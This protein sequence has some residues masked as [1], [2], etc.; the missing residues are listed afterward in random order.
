MALCS[1]HYGEHFSPLDVVK[2]DWVGQMVGANCDIL[3]WEPIDFLGV[4]LQF[5]LVHH[6]YVPTDRR[7]GEEQRGGGRETPVP[8]ARMARTAPLCTM[9][10][11]DSTC[12]AVGG[13]CTFS[14]HSPPLTHASLPAHGCMRE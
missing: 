7:D 9:E 6:L 12:V 3:W 2:R 11:S 14:R 4:G 1:N 8:S 13:E 5:H 10:H